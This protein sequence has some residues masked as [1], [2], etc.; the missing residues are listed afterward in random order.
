MS[1]VRYEPWNAA[2]SVHSDLSRLLGGIYGARTRAQEP[3][4]N[5]IPAADVQEETDGFVIHADVPGVSLSDIEVTMEE[6]TLSIRGERKL[7]RE[8]ES[9]KYIS[10]IERVHGSFTRRFQLPD[11]ADPGKVSATG[12]DGEL[13]VRIAKREARVPRRIEVQAAVESVDA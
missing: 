3:V 6:G 12:K 8:S 2:L 11:S 7:E 10:R 9:D 4:S 5:W 1:I 13:T